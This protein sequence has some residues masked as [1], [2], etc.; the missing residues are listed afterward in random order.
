VAANSELISVLYPDV[1]EPDNVLFSIFS[2]DSFPFCVVF[3]GHLV[4]PRHP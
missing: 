2:D 4:C 1:T 3:L